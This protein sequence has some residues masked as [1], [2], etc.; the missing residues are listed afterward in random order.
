MMMMM[1]ITDEE[2]IG[3]IT[4]V[5]IR[6]QYGWMDWQITGNLIDHDVIVIIITTTTTIDDDIH[7]GPCT[8]KGGVMRRKRSRIE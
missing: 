2:R 7:G 1:M 8:A 3:S 5:R 4:R 6:R